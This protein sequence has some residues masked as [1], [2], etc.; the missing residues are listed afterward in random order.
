MPEL[1]PADPFPPE[2]PKEWKEW[3]KSY[4]A[5]LAPGGES[6][7]AVRM[8]DDK[9]MANYLVINVHGV[10]IAARGGNWGT[11]NSRKRVS[12]ERLVPDFKPPQQANLN[13]ILNE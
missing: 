3:W 12:R 6:S 7:S 8:I 2:Y 10:R 1:R 4:A 5:S 9:R 13:I 11:D